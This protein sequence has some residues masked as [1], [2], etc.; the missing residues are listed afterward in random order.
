MKATLSTYRQSPRKVRLLADAL[1]GM[2]V[3]EA[4]QALRFIVKRAGG[5]VEKLLNSAVA[6]A[7]NNHKVAPEKLTIDTF[8]VDQGPTLK[9]FR[10]RARGRASRINK[11]TS[12]VTI[13]LK[14]K[15]N[16]KI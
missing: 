7:N 1:R 2:S 14:E 9:R 5:A 13:T 16:V 3:P 11:R 15:S 6:N 12:H 8:T 10:A 4:Q